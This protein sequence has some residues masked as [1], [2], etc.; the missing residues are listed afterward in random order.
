MSIVLSKVGEEVN[1]IIKGWWRGQYC[2]Q[3]L[4]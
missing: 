2:Y 1:S 3:R 4:V